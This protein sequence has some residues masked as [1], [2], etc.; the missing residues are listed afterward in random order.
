M[1]VKGSISSLSESDAAAPRRTALRQALAVCNGG[2]S[3]PIT[4]TQFEEALHEPAAAPTEV[5]THMR[6]LFD[7]DQAPV[8]Q[9]LVSAGVCSFSTIKNGLEVWAPHGV[10]MIEWASRMA[11]LESNERPQR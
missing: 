8:L 9:D 10:A 2:F 6:R 7:G 5:A 3:S 1:S 11:D 4:A